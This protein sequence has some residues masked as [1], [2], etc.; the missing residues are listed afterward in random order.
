VISRPELATYGDQT[1]WEMTH[2]LFWNATAAELEAGYDSAEPGEIFAVLT[3]VSNYE[4][5]PA[6]T[7]AVEDF[8]AFLSSRDPRGDKLV[9]VTSAMEAT[10]PAVPALSSASLLVLAVLLAGASCGVLRRRARGTRP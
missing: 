7:L 1:V 6:N 3:H 8:F 10:L 2:G 5:S 9:T 4:E